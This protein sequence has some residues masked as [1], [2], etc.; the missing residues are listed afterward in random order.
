M[1]LITTLITVFVT[2][3]GS[4]LSQVPLL[5]SNPGVSN[6]VIYLDFDGQKVT[7][8]GWNSGNTINAAAS[9]ALNNSNSI[10]QI[11]NR[12]SEDYRPFNVNVTTDSVR[13][14]NAHPT[15]RIRVIFTPTSAW[16]GSAGGVAFLGSFTWGG[17]P[18]TPC[19]IFE[20]QL[21]YSNKSMAEAASHEVGHT[22]SLMHQSTYNSSCVKTAEYNSGVGTGVTSWAPIMG[23]GYNRNVTLWHNGKNAT[24]CNTTQLDHGNGSPGITGNPYLSFWPDDVGDTYQT[25]KILN[26][27]SLTLSDSGIVTTPT[28]IDVY[29]FEIC[30]PRYVTVNVRPW[31]LDSTPGSYL[32]ANLDVKLKLFNASGTM[33]VADSS[34]S[35][36]NGLVGLNL[37]AGSYYFTVDGGSSAY[38][39][40]YG[41]IGKYY[42]LVK[43]N[44]PPQLNNS[45][46]MPGSVC[47]GQNVVLSYSSNGTPNN[48]QWTVSG[49]TSSTFA[50]ANPTFNFTGSGIYTLTLLA[51]GSNS[52][53]CVS[54][55]T[56][57][58][59]TL[60][61]LGISGT[62]T[63]LCPTKTASLVASGAGSYT[64]LPG[65]FNGVSVIMVPTVSTTYTLIGANGNCLNTAISTLSVSPNFSVN[66]AVSSSTICTG[67]SATITASGANNYTLYPGNLV[68]IPAVVS[69]TYNT[70]FIVT[71]ETNGCLRT[72]SK[73]IYVRPSYDITVTAS[74]FFI[75]ANQPVTLNSF[76]AS[77]YTVQPGNLT[78]NQVIVAP[79]VATIYT[80]TGAD[81]F[82]CL[83]DTTLE[84][85]INICDYNALEERGELSAMV[86]SPNPASDRF[87]IENVSGEFTIRVFN[88]LGKQ[89]Y[90]G[91]SEDQPSER[92]V[93]TLGW[94]KG[95]YFV[96]VTSGSS[97]RIRKLIIE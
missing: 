93:S 66:M 95:L 52:M 25:G 14:N 61:V 3:T 21:G 11:W 28:D 75:C 87:S 58:V 65:N 34:V 15:S 33:L 7:G 83:S 44:N 82:Q 12:V 85:F 31:A 81:V 49:P 50:I 22:L 35:K 88:S 77:T 29:R 23:V 68:A 57:D 73:I 91:Y 20:N 67:N 90:Y 2:I 53:S 55:K 86:I 26:L 30:N 71:G 59:N 19:W 70:N 6:K 9:N 79:S 51:T 56:I 62:Q 40:D 47:A 97:T 27:N 16:Y 17:Y 43:A 4:V 32:G 13:F 48:W 54:T 80:I 1:K 39:S 37:P 69:P 5:N 24:S 94:S 8:T 46:I 45:I 38:Y 96:N 41:S 18:G 72:V 92:I 84:L 78:G 74:E 36:L 64:W 10:R 60:P 42:V 63:V 76:G 89:I